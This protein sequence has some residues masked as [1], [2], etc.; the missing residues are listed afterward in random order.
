MQYAGIEKNPIVRREFL[1]AMLQTVFR[2]PEKSADSQ[3]R[4]GRDIPRFTIG[5]GTGRNETE[6]TNWRA[7]PSAASQKFLPSTKF[8]R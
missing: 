3:M 4:N 2:I 5:A 8:R 7:P 1:Q 6:S